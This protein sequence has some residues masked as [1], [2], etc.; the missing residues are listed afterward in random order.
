MSQELQVFILKLQVANY[1][2]NLE[3][4]FSKT[5]SELNCETAS[6]QNFLCVEHLNCML[7]KRVT[8]N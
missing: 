7:L 5:F 1:E 6:C 8:E 3:L 2:S 4:Q